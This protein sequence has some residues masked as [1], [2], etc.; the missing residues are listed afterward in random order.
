[1][2]KILSK[3]EQKTTNGG[4]SGTCSVENETCTILIPVY[5]L[6]FKTVAGKCVQ[7]NSQFFCLP[8]I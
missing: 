5:P 6:G 3:K 1:M 8:N 7:S 2:F 4:Y